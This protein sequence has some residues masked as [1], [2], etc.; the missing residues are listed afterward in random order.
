MRKEVE[1]QL[2]KLK[3]ERVLPTNVVERWESLELT[4]SNSELFEVAQWLVRDNVFWWLA[5]VSHILPQIA[6]HCGF[7]DLVSLI[8]SQVR[9]DLAQASFINALITIGEKQPT[10]AKELYERIV[11]EFPSL[12]DYGGLLLGGAAR[13]DRSVR[14]RVITEVT[15]KSGKECISF[16]RALRIAFDKADRIEPSVFSILHVLAES[17]DPDIKRE[18]ALA[19]FDFYVHNKQ[20]SFEQLVRLSQS[21][22]SSVRYTVANQLSIREFDIEHLLELVRILAD[23]TDKFVLD[24]VTWTIATKCKA[25]TSFCMSIIK[26][27]VD[28]GKYFEI[29]SID[30]AL[31]EIGKTNL[32]H[33]LMMVKSWIEPKDFRIALVAPDILWR[34]GEY[35]VESLTNTLLQWLKK[36]RSRK[37][38]LEGIR[39]VLSE[40]YMETMKQD[41]I[42]DVCYDSLYELAK[43]E[44]IDADRV[45]R[46][47]NVK[48]F[49]CCTLIDELERKR[50]SIDYILLFSNLERFPNIKGF[51]G[52]DWFEKMR[53][54]QN[55]EHPLLMYLSSNLLMMEAIQSKLNDIRL[56]SDKVKQELAIMQLK[57]SQES[58][59]FLSYLDQNLSMISDTEPKVGEL[60]R[61]LKDTDLFWQTVSEIDVISRLRRK[62]KVVIGPTIELK[63]ERRVFKRNPDLMV[64]IGSSQTLIEVITPQMFRPLKYFHGAGIPNRLRSLVYT[65]FKEHFKGQKLER[66]VI[67]VVDVMRSEIDYYSAEGYLGGSFQITFRV[68]KT[69]GKV[70]DSF[71]SRADDAMSRLDPETRVIIG[72]IL[73]RRITGTDGKI[74]ISGRSFANES[75]TNENRRKVLTEIENALFG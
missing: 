20:K 72:L 15:E 9:G 46:R 34:L 51:I 4:L 64:T 66:D 16:I 1:S 22:H 30:W 68:D 18:V 17:S 52:S 37:V 11:T 67:I 60:K 7:L 32:K 47:E 57:D 6:I 44:G 25:Q 42:V 31:N 59:A 50:P 55:V 58:N 56:I 43:V 36:K 70:I 69:T 29:N 33:S 62:Y 49:K 65:E 27:W 71:P 13:A 23:D 21:S 26:K 75:V 12:L 19:Y 73:Y 2:L 41:T 63:Q 39:K 3:E 14:E 8:A 74:H 53:D 5:L 38:A 35:D 45:S 54:E 24:Q 28:S 61:G 48:I 40:R 10:V